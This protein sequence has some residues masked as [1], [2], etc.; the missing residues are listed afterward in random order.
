MSRQVMGQGRYRIER[1]IGDGGASQ[2]YLAFDQQRQAPVAVKVLSP[3]RAGDQAAVQRF[4]S[5]AGVLSQLRH[6]NIVQMFEVFT[7]EGSYCLAMEY[8]DGMTLQQKVG[9]GPLPIDQAVHVT[10]SVCQA[11]SYAHSQGVI[12]RDVKASNIMIGKDGVV[13]VADFGIARLMADGAR[14]AL[15]SGSLESMAPEVI[16]GQP[17][18][19]RSEV[20]SVGV[21]LYQ[22]LTGQLPFRAEEPAAVAYQHVATPPRME[23]VPRALSHV[24]LT[25]LAKDPQARYPSTQALAAALREATTAA[26]PLPRRR[27]PWL[28]VLSGLL[29]VGVLSL[30]IYALLNLIGGAAGVGDAASAPAP[31]ATATRTATPQPS[32]PTATA[33]PA[34]TPSPALPATAAAPP[35]PVAS[36]TPVIEATGTAIAVASPATDTPAAAA[37]RGRIAYTVAV[38]PRQHYKIFLVNADGS[39]PRELADR[40]GEPSFAPDGQRLAFYV[41]LD[42]LYTMAIDGSDRR[43][44]VGDGEAAF[45]AWSP[46]GNLIAFHSTRGNSGR[47]DIYVVNADGSGERMLTDGEQ[48]AWAPDSRRLVYK[49]CLGNDCG[50][51]LINVDGS[52]KQRLT[53][54][55]DDGN[56]AWSPDGRWVAFTSHRDGNHEIYVMRPDGSNQRR[57]TNTPQT[58]GLPVWLPGGQHIAFRSDRDGQWAIYVMRADGSDVRKVVNAAV[59]PDRWIWEKMDATD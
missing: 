10:E 24:V 40:A 59:A 28:A 44:I 31:A 20:Y 30:L 3:R 39:G 22:M 58:E 54:Y 17:A 13:K 18:D 23:H 9:R 45:P 1:P 26:A 7:E 4:L 42:G 36:T 14:D 48:A 46:D 53:A 12:H 51:M 29:L 15:P 49:G 11:L 16:H 43:Q 27:R 2:V 55:A 38:T 32:Q 5:A 41:W 35:D 57:L 52:G 33:L 19:E 21:V 25:A 8:V 56:P 47:F 34:A 50:L 6:P 37:P